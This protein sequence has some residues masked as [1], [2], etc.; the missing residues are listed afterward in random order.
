MLAIL[1]RAALLGGLVFGGHAVIAAEQTA[2]KTEPKKAELKQADTQK[3]DTKT[4]APKAK[5]ATAHAAV[6]QVTDDMMAIIRRSTQLMAD[7]PKAYYAQV[8]DLLEPVVA[9]SYIAKSVMGQHY[10]AATKAQR[11]AFAKTFQSTMVETFAKG[12][13]NYSDFKI[14][15]VPPTG[16]VSGQRKVQVIQEVAG[17]DGTNTVAYTMGQSKTGD[18]LLIN[19]VLNGINLGSNFQQQ[20][21]QAMRQHKNDV[22]S[23]IATWGES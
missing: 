2:E 4:A 8:S 12:L 18:W 16:D 17:K 20:F 6:T 1:V 5:P 11:E 15:T 9:F 10:K 19:V 7:D 21:A 13:A 3:A 23:V 22:D 14:T